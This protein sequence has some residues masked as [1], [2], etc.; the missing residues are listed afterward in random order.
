M[1]LIVL[2]I[3][4][5]CF[6]SSLFLFRNKPMNPITFF[7]ALWSGIIFLSILG[8]Y[9]LYPASNEAYLLLLLMIVCFFAGGV[10]CIK[11]RR[12]LTKPS[13]VCEEICVRWKI[14]YLLLIVIIII[15]LCDCVL[16]LKYY[17]DG[18]EMT[19]LKVWISEPWG[20]ENPILSRRTLLEESFRTLIIIPFESLIAPI[21]SYVL[22]QSTEKNRKKCILFCLSLIHL[23]LGSL[24]GGGGRLGFICYGG[25]FLLAYFTFVKKNSLDRQKTKMYRRGFAIAAICGIGLIV[26]YTIVRSGRGAFLKQAYTYFAMPPTLLSEWLPELKEATH[27]WGGLTLFGLHSYFFRVLE[28]L[29]LNFL[30]PDTYYVLY[31]HILNA[32]KFLQLGFG[33]GNSFV[34]PIYYFYIDGGYFFVCAAS[35]VLG[36]VISMLYEKLTNCINIRSFVMY[37]MIMYAV[38]VSF[39]RT[40]TAIPV[41]WLGFLMAMAIMKKKKVET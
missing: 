21:T 20:S 31:Q 12:T 38:F 8:L 39:M 27:T 5:I 36:G 29:K 30:I 25:C 4:F 15:K 11:W 23:L 40:S 41:F 7:L 34:T 6:I 17:R 1:G 9:G 16:L 24:S 10:V 32:D 33:T 18:I 19:Q 22:F 37:I 26:V 13:K 14:Y 28:V 3:C 35:A 2:C